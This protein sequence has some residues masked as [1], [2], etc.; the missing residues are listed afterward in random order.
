MNARRGGKLRR[1]KLRRFQ[2]RLKE[3]RTGLKK[4]W[5]V[6]ESNNSWWKAC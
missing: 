6:E 3:E 1:S 5:E 2:L 4:M